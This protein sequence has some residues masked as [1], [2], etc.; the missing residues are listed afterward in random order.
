MTDPQ[1]LPQKIIDEAARFCSEARVRENFAQWIAR[2]AVDNA[3]VNFARE[4]PRYT[5]DPGV[6]GREKVVVIA[7]LSFCGS[8]SYLLHGEILKRAA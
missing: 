1:P 4:A 5:V 8:T 3:V 7:A 2:I 6:P